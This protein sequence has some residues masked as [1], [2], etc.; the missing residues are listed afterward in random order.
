[1]ASG[2]AKGRTS[3][4]VFAHFAARIQLGKESTVPM[5]KEMHNG[6]GAGPSQVAAAH[7]FTLLC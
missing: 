6:A 2:A 7:A 3:A 4:S 5:W 1:M